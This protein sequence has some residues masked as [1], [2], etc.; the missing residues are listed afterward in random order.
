MKVSSYKHILLIVI[1]HILV[2]GWSMGIISKDIQNF[3]NGYRDNKS[4]EV[5]PERVSYQEYVAYQ[6]EVL[7]ELESQKEYLINQFS[8]F[9]NKLELPIDFEKS[10]TRTFDGA[11][12]SIY[13]GKKRSSKLR[14]LAMSQNKTLFTLLVALTDVLLYL[15]SKEEDIV[16]GT[17]TNNIR[18]DER[19]SNNVGY[20]LNTLAIKSK[21]EREKT[22]LDNFHK[23]SIDVYN[24]FENSDYPFDKLIEDLKLS[25]T[26]DKNPLFSVM[27]ILQNFEQHEL[28]F[29]GLNVKDLNFTGNGSKFDLQLEFIDE[30]D[31]FLIMQ[32]SLDLFKEETILKIRDN[33]IDLIDLVVDKIDIPIE[34]LEKELGLDNSLEMVM[35]V[36]EDIDEDF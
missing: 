5:V 16:I 35:N 8:G 18:Q 14:K 19:F 1:H 3:Y 20:F 13:L 34:L 30:E 15:Y 7:K 17:P 12:T 4:I 9:T 2:D 23:I 25:S 26:V 24:G 28:K 36:Y 10:D 22:F 33:F 11:F 6:E 32:Y 21:V 31:I 29:N 27:V